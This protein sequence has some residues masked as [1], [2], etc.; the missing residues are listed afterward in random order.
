MAQR[1]TAECVDWQTVR[2]QVPNVAQ[3]VTLKRVVLFFHVIVGFVLNSALQ[4]LDE[5]QERSSTRRK[6]T[7]L[8][9]DG[10]HAQLR[11]S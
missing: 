4:G 6:W 1:S 9:E 10:C 11:L 8:T 5:S 2:V 3:P 7:T